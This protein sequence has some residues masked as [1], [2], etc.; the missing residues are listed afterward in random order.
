MRLQPAN[1]RLGLLQLHLAVLLAGGA[2]LFA[3]FVAVDAAV[4]TCARTVFGSLSLLAV[5][6]ATRTALRVRGTRDLLLFAV[7]G[8]VLAAHWFTFFLS[9]QVSTVAIGLLGFSSFPLFV[10][11]LEPL[12]FR[13]RL[14]RRD[15]AA[16]AVVTAGLALVVPS[17]D[18][19]DRMT[20][21]L[22][23][24]LASALTFA[25]LSLLNRFHAGSYPAIA[26]SFWQQAVAALCMLP[27]ALHWPG[28]PTARDWALM[29]LLGVV[30]T[31]LGQGLIVASLRHLRAQTASVVF[32]LEAVY[33]I[34]LGWL[35]LAETPDLR[36]LAGGA[37]ICGAAL[38]ASLGRHDERRAAVPAQ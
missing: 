31:G 26:V 14:R 35:L 32:G 30:F 28:A 3:K 15:V 8:A 16:A 6:L 36:T 4:L 5:A 24:G 20:Q 18:A 38:W 13:E 33:G 7:T 21:G 11:F 37:L 29:V 23:W 9:I 1:H 12:F 19:G 17:F 2:G 27:A 25:V 22:L 10:T 34:A